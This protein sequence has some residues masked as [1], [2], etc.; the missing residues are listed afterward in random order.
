M[1][2][3]LQTD[4]TNSQ[5]A[6]I[7][8]DDAAATAST[9]STTEE[10]SQTSGDQPND[11]LDGDAGLGN[12][13]EPTE[14]EA[15]AAEEARRAALTDEERQAE[16]DA[17]AAADLKASYVGAP[18][19]DYELELPEGMTLDPAGLEAI[20]PIARDLNLSSAGLSHLAASAY[21][22]VEGQVMQQQVQQVMGVRKAWETESRA[23]I[24][25]GKD[26]DPDPAFAGENYDAVMAT[27]AKTMD[28]FFPGE[29]PDA[30]IDPETGK[31]VP[32]S[33][34]DWLKTTGLGL[35][36]AMIRGF[37]LIG[38]KISED[39]F[40][41]SHGAPATKRT[42]EEKYYGSA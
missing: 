27:A 23:M 41:T 3:E 6:A 38:T 24:S 7:Q 25:G 20:T 22:I 16:D 40:E 26:R 10:N 4:A 28:T 30:K 36:P 33:F 8:T 2:D 31:A 13:Q 29:Y 19:G 5:E 34:R 37:Y 21:P 17:K 39:S 32:G 14:E 9:T 35:H 11:E 1:A 12:E 42:R 18:E 15:A